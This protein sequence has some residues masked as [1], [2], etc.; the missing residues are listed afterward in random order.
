MPRLLGDVLIAGA[1]TSVTF[2]RQKTCPNAEMS[3]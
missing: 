1:F 3:L 2:P